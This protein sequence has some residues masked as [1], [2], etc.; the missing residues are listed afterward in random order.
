MRKVGF[1]FSS[2]AMQVSSVELFQFNTFCQVMVAA[3][4][5]L[6]KIYQETANRPLRYARAEI[7]EQNFGDLNDCFQT[8]ITFSSQKQGSH[9]DKCFLFIFSEYNN[10]SAEFS[11]F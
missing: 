4:W 6:F 1:L 8:C 11:I 9:F 7:L 10:F 3:F 5:W 2:Q